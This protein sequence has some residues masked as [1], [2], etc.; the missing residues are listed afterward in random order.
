MLSI[1]HLVSGYGRDAVLRG[2]SFDVPDRSV[3]AVFG[4]NGAG[5]SSLVRALIGL[6]PAWEGRIA[7]NGV[8]LAKASSRQRV[9]AG[10]AVSFQDQA[11]FPTLTVAAN[12]RLGAHVRWRERPFV[13]ERTERMLAL[14]PKL[15]DRSAQLAYTLS[16]G[17]RR[18]LSIGMALMTDPDIVILDEPSTGLSPSVT[19]FV[20]D[21]AANIRDGL[22]K[23]VIL[24]EQNVQSVLAFADRAIVLKTGSVIFDGAPATL[25]DDPEL[26]MMF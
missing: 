14:F 20:F 16:G 10:L 19:E 7:L 23:S 12:L 1:Q 15:R 24:V 9:R 22:G 5:K 13:A 8:E 3:T 2:V 6:L 21:T 17:E 26:V 4:H 25:R 18:M 11:V